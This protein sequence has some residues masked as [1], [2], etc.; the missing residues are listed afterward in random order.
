VGFTVLGSTDGWR[1]A[2]RLRQVE[3]W[4][5][6]APTTVATTPYGEY[7]VSGRLD[8]LLSGGTSESFTL[9]RM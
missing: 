1:S 6:P 7:V 9:R 3:P 8:V 5:D 4:P 2:S